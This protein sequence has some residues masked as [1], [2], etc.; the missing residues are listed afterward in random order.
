MN[1]AV[2]THRTRTL[3]EMLFRLQGE[4]RQSTAMEKGEL[5]GV[6]EAL[7]RL[8]AGKYGQCLKCGGAISIERLT[9]IP[10]ASYCVDCQKGLNCVR[11]GCG[12]APYDDQWSI[13]R[14]GNQSFG[15]VG[16]PLQ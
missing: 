16:K 5:R 15:A 4:G 9:G 1:G 10:F 11:G 6:D 13:N 2:T 14:L 8:D 12:Y 7:T 3:R